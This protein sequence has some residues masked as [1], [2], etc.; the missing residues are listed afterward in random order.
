MK[1][2]FF[3]LFVAILAIF[4]AAAALTTP[5]HSREPVIITDELVQPVGP[6]QCWEAPDLEEMEVGK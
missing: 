1:R 6:A 2:F 3:A 4:A 5:V